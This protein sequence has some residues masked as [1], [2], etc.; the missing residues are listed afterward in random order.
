[1][2][3]ERI[4]HPSCLGRLALGGAFA[5]LLGNPAMAAGVVAIGG[6]TPGPTP[7]I[8]YIGATVTQGT[9]T[10]VLFSIVPTAGSYTRPMTASISA[11]SLAARG[12]LSGNNLIIPVFGLYAGRTN[13]VN[14]VFSFAD[15]STSR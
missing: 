8:D 5:A 7:F 15:G 3:R 1:M 6:Q 2:R 11:A 10:N 14:L 9:L 13:T 4:R 12:G